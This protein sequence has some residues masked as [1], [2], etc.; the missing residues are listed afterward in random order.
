M[1][2]RGRIVATMVVMWLWVGED[3][4]DSRFFLALLLQ[5]TRDSRAL[6][7]RVRHGGRGAG[8]DDGDGL[9]VVDCSFGVEALGNDDFRQLG[10]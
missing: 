2:R 6:P 8:L 7:E 10:V 4:G 1:R 3:L 5:G 9:L